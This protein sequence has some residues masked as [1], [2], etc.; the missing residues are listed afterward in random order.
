[1]GAKICCA[2]WHRVADGL[3]DLLILKQLCC[4]ALRDGLRPPQGE[5]L[6]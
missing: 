2:I 4:K 6:F 3:T 1:M 5:E